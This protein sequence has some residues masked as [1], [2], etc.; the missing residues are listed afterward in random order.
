MSWNKT[1]N[2]Y[3]IEVLLGAGISA[4]HVLQNTQV[5]F[6]DILGLRD[7]EVLLCSCGLLHL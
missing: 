2:L 5:Y 3:R 1:A 6:C 7:N 4:A